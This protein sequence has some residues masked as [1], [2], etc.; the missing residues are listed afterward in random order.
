MMHPADA[1]MLRID[2]KEL[3]E[4]YNKIGSLQLPC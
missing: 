1:A 2:N 3:V 4:V